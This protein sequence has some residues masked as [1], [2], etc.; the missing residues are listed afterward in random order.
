MGGFT[1]DHYAARF[2]E[3]SAEL[4]AW[5]AQGKLKLPEHIERRLERFPQALIML[6]EGG[7]M[8]KLLVAP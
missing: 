8:G 1:V 5:M 7:H 3:A 6:F 2:P 4:A